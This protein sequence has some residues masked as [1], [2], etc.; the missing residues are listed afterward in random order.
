MDSLAVAL[1]DAPNIK[2]KT[3]NM[4]IENIDLGSDIFEILGAVSDNMLIFNAGFILGLNGRVPLILAGGTQMVGVLLIVNRILDYMGG[5]IDSSNLA[6]AT[7]KWVAEDEN[8]N[9]E[10]LIEMLNFQIN[11][12]YIDFDFSSSKN[13]LLKLYD[14]GEAKEGVG[15]GASLLYGILNGLTKE[16][17]IAKV[18]TFVN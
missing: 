6:L 5:E 15:A 17:I 14:N 7:T 13:G 12:Y 16:N 9:I 11:S 3:V 10:T 4:A 8:S 1:E 2:E 18:E